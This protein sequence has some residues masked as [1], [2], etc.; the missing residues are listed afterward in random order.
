MLVQGFVRDAVRNLKIARFV[1][2]IVGL[3]RFEPDCGSGVVVITT[4]IVLRY[5]EL[6]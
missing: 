1:K 6:P 2:I 4:L 5:D 3:G